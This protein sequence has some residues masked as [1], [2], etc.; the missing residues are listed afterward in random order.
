LKKKTPEVI[1]AKA[2]SVNETKVLGKIDLDAN[3]P[4]PRRRSE[5]SKRRSEKE[6]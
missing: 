3:K 4:A 1:R 5:R 2:P 6:K